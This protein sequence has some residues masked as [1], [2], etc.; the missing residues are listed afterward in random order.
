[1]GIRF[2]ASTIKAS[3]L[4]Q[5]PDWYRYECVNVL[6]KVAASGT[7]K[8]YILVFEGR[9]TPGG[10]DEMNG[11]PVSKLVSEKADWIIYPI[12]VAANGG[13]DFPADTEFDPESLKGITLEA[14][15][16]RGQRQD[17]SPMN[18]LVEFRPVRNQ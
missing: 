10:T 9:Q 1:M 13:E 11:V 15:T 7:S 5:N 17:G 3:F 2:S 12:A 6:K 4:V 16:V 8:N 14:R 18:D